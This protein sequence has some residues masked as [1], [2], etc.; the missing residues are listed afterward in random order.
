MQSSVCSVTPIGIT[1]LPAGVL[2]C[3]S[4]SPVLSA[5]LYRYAVDSLKKKGFDAVVSEWSSEIYS[6]EDH[7]SM[8]DAV[9]CVRWVNPK[10]GFIEV[11]GIHVTRGMPLSDYGLAIG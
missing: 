10:G 2:A 8:T 4:I 11:S 9:Y 5:R 7:V 6:V 3:D 1:A